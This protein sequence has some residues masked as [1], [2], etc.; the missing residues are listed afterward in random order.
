MDL[1]VVLGIRLVRQSSH[2]LALLA[3]SRRSRMQGV[4]TDCRTAS[5]TGWQYRISRDGS[6]WKKGGK[7][8]NDRPGEL[9]RTLKSPHDGVTLP[10]LKP[11][12]TFTELN[13]R[14]QLHLYV[15]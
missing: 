7:V 15:R 5:L 10:G 1:W 8:L 13:V 11:Q 9:D 12:G 6:G 3:R 2:D 4:R 14:R